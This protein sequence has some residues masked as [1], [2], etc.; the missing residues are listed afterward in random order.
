MQAGLTAAVWAC[1]RRAVT[2]P[3]LL[4]GPVDRVVDP[5]LRETPSGL[6][7]PL[8]PRFSEACSGRASSQRSISVSRTPGWAF[9][10]PAERQPA[11]A[12]LQ[13]PGYGWRPLLALRLL[14]RGPGR[15][16]RRGCEWGSLGCREH[17]R[18]SVSGFCCGREGELRWWSEAARFLAAILSPPCLASLAT[19][20]SWLTVCGR[21]VSAHSRLFLLNI[22]SR[23]FAMTWSR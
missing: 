19:R 9:S 18:V 23:C 10:A 20:R 5:V 17:G 21:R 2:G 3:G 8:R 12:R 15:G 16:W 7:H 4:S 14:S 1:P 22:S 6:V 13:G 11:Q